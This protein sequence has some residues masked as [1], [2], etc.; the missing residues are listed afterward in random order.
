[1]TAYTL[2]VIAI[3]LSAAVFIRRSNRRWYAARENYRRVHGDRLDH[4]IDDA[5]DR[6]SD[7]R[8]ESNQDVAW[9]PE[10]EQPIG[11]VPTRKLPPRI[12]RDP[13]GCLHFRDGSMSCCFVH[14]TGVLRAH[15][16]AKADDWAAQLW[17]D[18]Q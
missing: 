11:M 10:A 4:L 18:A 15:I 9:P 12:W 8:G 6:F 1:M 2:I 13:C 17:E 5:S 16:E 3:L 14:D 7:R